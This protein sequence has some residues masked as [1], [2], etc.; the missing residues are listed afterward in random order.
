LTEAIEGSAGR[1]DDFRQLLT[2]F[3]K[4][5]LKEIEAKIREEFE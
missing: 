4:L 5:G 2:L 1:E 3:Q